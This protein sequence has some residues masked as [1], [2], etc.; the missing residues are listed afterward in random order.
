MTQTV[1]RRRHLSV[2]SLAALLS[3]V[4]GSS[5]ICTGE[6]LNPKTYHSVSGAFSLL[7]D[8][9]NPEGA[10]SSIAELRMNGATA[11][12]R[13]FE[14]TLWDAAV[15]DD[16]SI[17]GYAYRNGYSGLAPWGVKRQ[18]S[19]VDVLLISSLGHVVT[20]HSH[21][22]RHEPGVFTNPPSPKI[23]VVSWFIPIPDENLA[24]LEVDTAVFD[25]EPTWWRYRINTGEPLNPIVL[26][27]PKSEHRPAQVVSMRL[28][29]G[30]PLIATHWS[31]MHQDDEQTS[32]GSRVSLRDLKGVE[33][34]AEDFAGDY[35]ELGEQAG[36]ARWTPGAAAQLRVAKES[37]SFRSCAHDAV[38]RYSIQREGEGWNIRETGRERTKD[39]AAYFSD[40][41]RTPPSYE[42]IKL[43]ALA[44]ITLGGDAPTGFGRVHGFSMDDRQRFGFV[45][46]ELHSRHFRMIDSDGAVLMDLALDIPKDSSVRATWLR[47]DTWLI[48]TP[49]F[50]ADGAWLLDLTTRALT[51]LPAFDRT[52]FDH[53]TPLEDGGFVALEAN[54]RRIVRVDASGDVLWRRD[55]A[56]EDLC[57][58]SA[59]EIVALQQ[60]PDRLQFFDQNGEATRFIDLEDAF[61]R[62]PQYVTEIEAGS[63]GRVL[64]YD[65]GGGD[66]SKLYL[67]NSDGTLRTR[68][69]PRRANGT[70]FEPRGDVRV[71]PDGSLWVTDG[72][73]FFQL[74]DQGATTQV[75]GPSPAERPLDKIRAMTIGDDGLIYALNAA[76]GAV[77]VFESDGSPV[78]VMHPHAIDSGTISGLPSMSVSGAGT[79]CYDLEGMVMLGERG[80]MLAFSGDG[81]TLGLQPKVLDS[82]TET[83]LFQPGSERFWAIGYEHIK[84]VGEDKET[85]RSIRR[86]PDRTWID[87]VSSGAVAEDGSL[88][89]AVGSSIGSSSGGW[90]FCVY[91]ADGEPRQTIETHGIGLT[92]SMA[93]TSGQIVVV[94]R[95]GLLIFDTTGEAPIRFF[96]LPEQGQS[97]WYV[98]RGPTPNEV[99]VRESASRELTR[100]RLPD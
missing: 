99:F 9:S 85:I 74:N 8:P 78:R 95:R 5:R 31:V 29:Q 98:Y 40:P 28:V 82:V 100:L 35:D 57:V 91:G 61:D 7:V 11:W 1:P 13:E 27:E 72:F 83:W 84:L 52:A 51:R 79:V 38:I 16:G 30:T 2:L 71:A 96:K 62:K 90:A 55:I 97:Y 39:D 42:E 14:F 48:H 65:F 49:R 26:P 56:A 47:G 77:H 23:P 4:L 36:R 18:D 75:V 10:G 37:L 68:F 50:S 45:P 88:A 25:S 60:F 15:S 34:W 12:R 89:L 69:G 43:E 3:A 59:G 67:L 87:R 24:L 76:N 17:F 73:A 32:Y 20:R 70:A 92:S 53:A 19:A 22:R 86:R 81:E 6:T 21:E 63:E 58:T 33:I 93:F 66:F 54:G 94:Y 64:V 46:R 44:R 80:G 41:W